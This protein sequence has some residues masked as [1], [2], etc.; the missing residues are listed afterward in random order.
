[1]F[2]F[3]IAS[4]VLVLRQK[5]TILGSLLLPVPY[6]NCLFRKWLHCNSF[7]LH[8]PRL[9][10]LQQGLGPQLL[11]DLKLFS[12]IESVLPPL[13]F[14]K[15][16]FFLK[17]YIHEF[18]FPFLQPLILSLDEALDYS[19]IFYFL[20]FIHISAKPYHRQSNLI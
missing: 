13:L 20:T 7:I 3:T 19:T 11:L 9:E 10:L 14:F 17:A 6:G 16:I 8:F 5:T 1:M 4:V 12:S 15:T 2:Q 18:I